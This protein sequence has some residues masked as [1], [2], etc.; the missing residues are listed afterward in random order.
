MMI[1]VKYSNIPTY[2]HDSFLYQSL[3]S[4]DKSS[5][6]EIPDE[7][8]KETDRVQN[9]TELTQMLHVT[10]F[11]GL[12]N[13]PLEPVKFCFENISDA[14]PVVSAFENA[15]ADFE[16]LFRK[17]YVGN[18]LTAAIK[19][20]KKDE[21]VHYLV[22]VSKPNNNL[23]G[24]V[25]AAAGVGRIDL[26][27]ML[28]GH[29]WEITIKATAAAARGGHLDCL[30]FLRNLGYMCDQDCVRAAAQ[31]GHV[32]CLRFLLVDCQATKLGIMALAA[33]SG[34]LECLKLLY[35]LG[36]EGSSSVTAKR[37]KVATSS[38]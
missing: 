7:C 12:K 18:A 38:V 27:E 28:R 9:V 32:E 5:E 26:I 4:E 23:M 8:Y 15:H 3:D 36:Y 24:P 20:N 2:L 10:N 33:E 29:G 30:K 22:N 13:L 6:I 25:V 14:W 1:F 31:H 17:G 34:H 21:I 37:R 35:D 16:S 11:W 19:T